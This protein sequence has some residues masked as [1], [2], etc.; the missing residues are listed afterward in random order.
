MSNQVMK[1]FEQSLSLSNFDT[2]C[3]FTRDLG[4]ELLK[5]SAT[6]EHLETLYKSITG[7]RG[8][9]LVLEE[10]LDENKVK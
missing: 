8:F 5:G 10:K 2:N 9:L 7:V 4:I 1:N 3:R 6:Q